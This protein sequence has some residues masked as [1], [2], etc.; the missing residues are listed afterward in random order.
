VNCYSPIAE[1]H[2]VQMFSDIG[3]I[4][5]E[6]WMADDRQKMRRAADLICARL[7]SWEKRRGMGARTQLLP[8]ARQANRV[9]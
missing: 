9:P 1:T 3:D 7:V 2:A 4:T 6:A 5:H 8:R